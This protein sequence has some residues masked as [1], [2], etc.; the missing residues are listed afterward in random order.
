M[1]SKGAQK[2]PDFHYKAGQRAQITLEIARILS[3]KEDTRIE[4]GDVE[5]RMKEEKKRTVESVRQSFLKQAEHRA[6]LEKIDDIFATILPVHLA[7]EE[8][9]E[10]AKTGSAK[11]PKCVRYVDIKNHLQETGKG[12]IEHT[13]SEFVEKVLEEHN[14]RFLLQKKGLKSRILIADCPNGIR[15]ALTKDDRLI[16]TPVTDSNVCR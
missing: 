12:N 2:G 15:C 8:L 14:F 9:A 11:K 6:E 16:A 5:D 10:I 13:Q 3:G 4:Y 1:L 7:Q